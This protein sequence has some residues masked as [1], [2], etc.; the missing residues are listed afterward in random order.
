MPYTL[1]SV[2]IL[3]FAL[4]STYGAYKLLLRSHWFLKWLRGTSGLLLILIIF[5]LSVIA[6]DVFSYQRLV[7]EKNI[8][9]I[10]F[11][12]QN[13]QQYIA[14]LV[15]ENNTRQYELYGDQWQLDSRIIKWSNTLARFGMETG[16]RLDRLS[17]RYLSLDDE[18]NKPRKLY[19]LEES[20]LGV[21]TW[22]W[23]NQYDEL[24]TFVDARYGSAVFLPM[25]NDGF[26]Q[27]SLTNSG[28]I[29][30]PLNQA[31]RD[32]MVLWQ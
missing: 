13:P 21:D 23:L 28:L 27:I 29:A 7:E 18:R 22:M 17:G 16:Y 12:Q 32:A 26:Y 20:S 15:T 14:T 3:L 10:R 8:A 4:L 24:I 25:V 19:A 31:A 2:V 1:L 5:L 30:R 11:K 9:T 6:L